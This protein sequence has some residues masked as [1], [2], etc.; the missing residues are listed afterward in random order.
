M[1]VAFLLSLKHLFSG[2]LK[3][4]L[5]LVLASTQ[6]ERGRVYRIAEPASA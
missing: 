3:K 4:K 1:K 2:M 5:G 6:Q